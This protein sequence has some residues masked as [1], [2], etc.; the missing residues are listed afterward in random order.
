MIR[1]WGFA[2]ML[3]GKTS[4]RY[5]RAD[6]FTVV[7]W[8]ETILH[9]LSE[10]IGIINWC[11]LYGIKMFRI[12]SKLIPLATH[13]TTIDKGFIWEKLSKKLLLVGSLIK[14]SDI[15]VSTHPQHFTILNSPEQ[16][17]VNGSIRD[18]VYNYSLLKN[19]GLD[20]FDIVLHVGGVYGDKDASRERFIRNWQKVPQE[21][22]GHIRLENDDKSWT[23]EDVL[24][25]CE[26]LN[27]PMVLDWHHHICNDDGQAMT[28]WRLERVFQTWDTVGT[29][30]KVHLSSPRSLEKP[31]PHSTYINIDYV[32]WI[33]RLIESNPREVDIMVEA[34]AKNLAM[35]RVQTEWMAKMY[36][37]II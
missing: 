35:I 16:S 7:R 23:V 36:G 6:H 2:C 31:R 20:H 30:P 19:M 3:E 5:V 1:R 10:T 26:E 17:V 8:R 27:I 12:N 21:I 11:K 37:L 32:D 25:I 28:K 9:N 24:S 34:K 22:R 13:P 4:Y 33:L 15:R 14:K 18:I 29:I